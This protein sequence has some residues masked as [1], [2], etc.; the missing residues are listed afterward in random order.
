MGLELAHAHDIDFVMLDLNLPDI[1]GEE[2]LL[3][4]KAD[5]RTADIPVLVVSAD[6]T[7]GRIQRLRDSG[8]YDY[9]TK[10]IDVDHLLRVIDANFP[11]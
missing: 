1:N 11:E 4:L 10:P 7:S 2:V 8:A 3:R 5:P 9:I 6:A